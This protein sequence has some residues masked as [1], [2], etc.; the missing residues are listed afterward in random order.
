MDKTVAINLVQF[1]ISIIYS[2]QR[3]VVRKHKNRVIIS[4]LQLEVLRPG[5]NATLISVKRREVR[6]ELHCRED[7]T[8]Y[9]EM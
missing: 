6:T 2:L 1:N 8:Y 5:G 7:G 9:T 3:Q 4:I